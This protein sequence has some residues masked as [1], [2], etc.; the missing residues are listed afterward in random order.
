MQKSTEAFGIL[1]S[2]G[3][4]CTQPCIDWIVQ[5]TAENIHSTTLFSFQS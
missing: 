5:G 3:L 4:C 2:S 1:R